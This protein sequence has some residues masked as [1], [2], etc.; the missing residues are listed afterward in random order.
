MKPTLLFATLLLTAAA[1]AG[2]EPGARTP[3]RDS[4]RL[5]NPTDAFA[6][7]A[8]TADTAALSS[9]W[10]FDPATLRMVRVEPVAPASSVAILRSEGAPAR[11]VV[12]G[13]NTLRLGRRLILSNGQAYHWGPY[14]DAL[15]DARTLSFP[16]R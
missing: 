14:P 2:Q 16:G 1:A 7:A 3:D 10:R 8:G 11:V 5:G 13:D 12:L 4:V 15:L 6:A 9:Q